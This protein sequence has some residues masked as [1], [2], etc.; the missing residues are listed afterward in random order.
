ME[1]NIKCRY[2]FVFAGSYCK[3]CALYG[4]C[5]KTKKKEKR[6]GSE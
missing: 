4:M 2:G 6:K 3:V 1:R 5:E